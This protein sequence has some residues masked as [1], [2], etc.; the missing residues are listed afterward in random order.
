MS[1]VE[2]LGGFL[3]V[4]QGR[5]WSAVSREFGIDPQAARFSATSLKRMHA[6][7]AKQ[8]Q[9]ASGGRMHWRDWHSSLVIEPFLDLLADRERIPKKGGKKARAARAA[10]QGSAPA[11]SERKGEGRTAKEGEQMVIG[12]LMG[13]VGVSSGQVA[14]ALNVC[15]QLRH[16]S[17]DNNLR[18]TVEFLMGEAMVPANKVAKV[19]GTFPQI[20]GLSVESN[21][22]PML[23]YLT[24]DLG[25]SG[26]KIGKVLVTRP[27][28]LASCVGNLLPKIQTLLGP[29]QVPE[30]M[31][32]HIVTKAPHL[33]GL[34]NTHI[35]EMISFLTD[36][37]G[38]ERA[39]VGRLIVSSPQLLGLSIECN[40][41]PK[42]RFL[43]QDI[44]V[45][46]GKVGS[47]IGSFPNI[48]GYSVEANMLPKLQYLAEEV[49]E[50]PLRKMGRAV[51][52]CPQLLGYSL[53]KRI[54]PRHQLL[55]RR[56]MH[57]SISR[58]LAPSDLEFR[59]MLRTSDRARREREREERDASMP[60][61]E[62]IKLANGR[63]NNGL[64]QQPDIG[65][66]AVPLS[67]ETM[68]GLYYWHFN[69][70]GV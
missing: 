22:R 51:V 9:R 29:G 3:A 67:P 56:S 1:R 16:L 48:L 42:I 30:E 66:E 25:I 32:G 33:L 26:E 31:I 37:V 35:L 34:S 57:L 8:V 6:L 61:S 50:V 15:P 36:E 24:E 62:R 58:M 27:Q 11:A 60:Y 65:D 41:R 52:T 46:K 70:G 43:V 45:P 40:L 44:G 68:S 69:K 5:L 54:K 21:L 47:V 55:L 63:R 12:Y 59:R 49:L 28:L 19:V 64:P 2:E 38:V 20:L 23:T 39:R 4:T 7:L 18:P 10:C 13:E 53:E 14:K 17:V